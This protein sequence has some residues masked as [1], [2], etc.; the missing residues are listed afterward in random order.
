[1]IP[2][3]HKNRFSSMLNTV[4]LYLSS[5]VHNLHAKNCVQNMVQKYTKIV[6]PKGLWKMGKYLNI[7]VLHNNLLL[8][9]S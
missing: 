3:W 7:T 2:V 1:M 9:S 4:L 8:L 6:K 5:T